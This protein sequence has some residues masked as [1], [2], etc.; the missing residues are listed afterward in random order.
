MRSALE[1]EEQTYGSTKIGATEVSSPI[2]RSPADV[3]RQFYERK[4][5]RNLA[6]VL[7][8]LESNE[9]LRVRVSGCSTNFGSSRNPL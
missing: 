4:N 7:M 6:E 1:G 2:Q 8:D 3:I 9:V 5:T